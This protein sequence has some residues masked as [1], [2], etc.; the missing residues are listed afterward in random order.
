MN[1]LRDTANNTTHMI[2]KGELAVKLHAKH[3]KVGTSSDRNSRQNQV[4]VGRVHSPE[5]TNDKCFSFVRI[6]YRAPTIVK[7]GNNSGLSAG[8][9]SHLHSVEASACVGT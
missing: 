1:S 9:R 5:S 4:T 8:L 2:F 6:Q 7:G 3:V